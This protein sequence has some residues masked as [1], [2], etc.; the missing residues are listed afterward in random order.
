MGGSRPSP[1]TVVMP[2]PTAPTLY[3]SVTPLESYQDLAGQLRRIQ[4][5]TDQIQR[6]RFTEVGTPEEIGARQRGIEA[7]EAASYL[8][9]LPKG[10][11]TLEQTTG[12]KDPY[13][14]IRETVEGQL[15][16]AQ[17]AYAEAMQ[18]VGRKTNT[19]A[20]TETPSWAQRTVT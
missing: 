1:P 7:R 3:Q 2:T 16:D 17:K 13:K 8:A 14:P 15:T 12:L 20:V 4:E 6:Q 5:Q 19:T 9:S 10:D 18:K 11:T